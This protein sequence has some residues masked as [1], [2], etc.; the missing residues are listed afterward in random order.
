MNNFFC[1]YLPGYVGSNCIIDINDC[2]PNP[3][4]N[5]GKCYDLIDGFMCEFVTGYTDVN[6]A[7]NIDDCNPN[8]CVRIIE[9]VM[10]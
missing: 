2:D 9:L 1:T 7:T 10:I 8:P 4:D 6:C 3:C 5:N